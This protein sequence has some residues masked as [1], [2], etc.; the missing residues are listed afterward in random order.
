MTGINLPYTATTPRNNTSITKSYVQCLFEDSKGRLWIGTVSGGLDLF[1]R[2]TETFIHIK[3]QEGNN[4]GLPG[5]P[6][7]SVA[8]DRHGNIW[9]QAGDKLVKIT[10]TGNDKKSASEVFGIRRVDVPFHSDVSFLTI[11]GSGKIYYVD[12]GAGVMYRLE[13]DKPERWS[14]VLSPGKTL[15]KEPNP[16]A[17]TYSIV[18]LAEDPVAQ[19]LY[20]FHK[21]GVTRFNETTGKQEATFHNDF[22]RDFDSPLR[23][24]MDKSGTLWFSGHGNLLLYNTHTGEL[25]RAIAPDKNDSRLLQSSYSIYE[26]RSGLLWIGTAGYGILKRNIRSEFFHRTGAGASYSIHEADNGNILLGNGTAV[27]Q[28]FNRTTGQITDASEM[29]QDKRQNLNKFL[30]LPVST[31]REGEWFAHGS[32]LYNQNNVLKITVDYP[33]PVIPNDEYTDL[34]Q[35]KIKD[36]GGYIWL[37]TS[38][39]LLRFNIADKKWTAFKNNPNDP[40]SISSNVILSLCPDPLQPAKY[41]WAGTGGG[42][43]NRLD[44]LTSKC[45]SYSTEDGLPNNVIY[46]VLSDD[47]G[48]LWMS[49]NKGLSCFN[50]NTQTFRNFDHKDGLQ[51]NEFNRGAYY[52]TKDGCL[53]FGGVSGFNYFYPKDISNNTTVPRV[54]IT[55]FK[56][57]NEPV[58]VQQEHTPLSKAICLTQKLKLSYEQNFV[59][60]EFAAMDFTDPEKNMYRY[61][62]A[63]FDKSRISAGTAHTA[64]YSN[65][66]PGSYTFYVQGSNSDGT[67]NDEGTSIELI[68]LPPW[69]MTWWFYTLLITAVLFAGYTF[70][71]NRLAQALKLQAIRDKI[72]GDLHDEV[73]S[74]LSNIYIFSNVAQRTSNN[75]TAPLL[76]KINDYTQQSMEA[77]NDIVWMINTRNDRFENIMIRMRTLAVETSEA[78]N[79][80]LHLNFDERLDEVKLNME[81]RKNFYLIYKEAIN[82]IAKYAGCKSMW[83]D[84]KL[85]QKTVTLTIRDDGKG[86]DVA[87]GIKGNGM[88]NMK[89]RAGLLNGN[90]TVTSKPGEGT[91]LELNFKM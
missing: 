72:A 27:Q 12:G 81:E 69:Y 76:K 28:V 6:V 41:L 21:G 37:G 84:M 22:F 66:D 82:N 63:G 50:L 35:C 80:K 90:L 42:G 8:E 65:L 9:V 25:K 31:G 45:K 48:N 89:K 32:R 60:F 67:W 86:F 40:N 55:G 2:N 52:K 49:T 5:G 24:I 30:C 71:K 78:F 62:L 29:S 74:N 88:Y 11:T 77:M 79:C 34:I 14:V 58:T 83:I 53:F 16:S 39:G 91:T 44:L 51:S 20:V 46:G 7:K 26:D 56:I 33:L 61:R 3:K 18:Q 36:P 75:E 64:T 15:Q 4:N 54:N 85:H 73:G 68:I 23:A 87:N 43:I 70:Y 1:D 10:I 19:K 57:R 47:A 13:D 17:N 38:A 59:S